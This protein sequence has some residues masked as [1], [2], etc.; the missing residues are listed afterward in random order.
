MEQRLGRNAAHV[1]TH[2]A[3]GRR[4][5]HQDHVLTEL[6]DEYSYDAYRE[7]HADNVVVFAVDR[8]GRVRFPVGDED[9]EPGPGWKVAALRKPRN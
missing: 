1:E 8:K 5:F 4:L 2:P 6:T 7:A 3:E 9:V